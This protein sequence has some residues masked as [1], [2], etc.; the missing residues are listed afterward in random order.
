[1]NTSQAYAA[2]GLQAIPVGEVAR[3]LSFPGVYSLAQPACG[4]AYVGQS[5]NLGRRFEQHHEGRLRSSEIMMRLARIAEVE[6]RVHIEITDA[7]MG[8]DLSLR[9]RWLEAAIMAGY[10]ESGWRLTNAFPR[11][12]KEYGAALLNLEFIRESGL[13]ISVDGYPIVAFGHTTPRERVAT[14]G[15]EGIPGE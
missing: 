9:L 14:V 10:V 11:T 13:P 4:L 2:V 6:F 7:P 3:R 8:S 5:T 12:D 15:T 1:M